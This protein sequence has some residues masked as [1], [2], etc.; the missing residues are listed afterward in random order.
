[1]SEI[2]SLACG[3]VYRV[4]ERV[5]STE[6]AVTEADR[7]VE[8]IR[9]VVREELA[10]LVPERCAPSQH[11]CAM[12]DLLA[13]DGG[14]LV[15]ELTGRV[16]QMCPVCG[17]R[18]SRPAD[19]AASTRDPGR[20]CG[21]CGRSG[22]HRRDCNTGGS[23]RPLADWAKAQVAADWVNMPIGGCP[24]CSRYNRHTA[25]CPVFTGELHLVV[26]NGTGTLHTPV[27][28]TATDEYG[29]PHLVDGKR[30]TH[31]G[32]CGTVKP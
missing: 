8:L 13:Q 6:D 23:P 1:M 25:A 10:A 24:A 7:L 4:T 26:T 20:A 14:P 2:K 31:C 12:S 27:W 5:V 16:Q 22:T 18:G 3:F 9:A 30:Y 19:E 29:L 15:G 32:I 21:E 11:V 17:M 28:T